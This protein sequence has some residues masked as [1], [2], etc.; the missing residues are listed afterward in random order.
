MIT[1]ET[2]TR[3]NELQIYFQSYLS[4]ENS[5]KENCFIINEI[6]RQHNCLAIKDMNL[7]I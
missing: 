5:L 2:C 1:F 6:I 7:Y 3:I 4:S